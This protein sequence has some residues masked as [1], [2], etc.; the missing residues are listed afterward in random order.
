MSGMEIASYLMAIVYVISFL[1][2]SAILARESGR[3]IWLFDRGSESQ[4]LPATLFR[5]AFIGAVLWPLVLS[6]AGNP[7]ANDP[8]SAALDGPWLDVFGH[9]LI[10]VGACIAI[11]SQRYMGASWRI[12]AAQG[13]LGAIV[14]SGPFAISRNPVF[15]GQAILFAGLF[16]VLPSLIQAALT[17]ALLVAIALQ[18]GIEERV[19]HA[20]HGEAYLAYKTRVRRWLGVRRSAP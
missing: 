13:D 19:L 7:I 6:L 4:R 10:V 12:G 8:L 9:L 14:D 1:S 16:L 5:L 18:V 11:L 17:L 15:L 2:M 3:E 20:T